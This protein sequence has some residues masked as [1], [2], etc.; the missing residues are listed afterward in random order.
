MK[1]F[2]SFICYDRFELELFSSSLKKKFVKKVVG[3]PTTFKPDMKKNVSQKLSFKNSKQ[4]FK[5]T[6][7]N[8]G[9]A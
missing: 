5:I 4:K 2:H 3:I 9:L 1:T 6:L 7:N 8:P